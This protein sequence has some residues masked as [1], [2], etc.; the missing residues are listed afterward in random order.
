MISSGN[1]SVEL[2]ATEERDETEDVAD[3]Q[4]YCGAGREREPGGYKPSTKDAEG[5]VPRRGHSVAQPDHPQFD[6]TGLFKTAGDRAS[7]RA[8]CANVLRPM[9]NH[10]RVSPGRQARGNASRQAAAPRATRE[11]G[12]GVA[13]GSAELRH[14]PQAQSRPTNGQRP[15]EQGASA[16]PVGGPAVRPATKTTWRNAEP[17][18][19]RS[20]MKMV[21][22][23]HSPRERP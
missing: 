19:P 4:C 22:A 3:V 15:G 11:S 1:T 2:F 8:T 5:V 20:A 18:T 16:V 10:F 9:R 13:D 21:A 14:G 6:R 7:P 17:G 23:L 12:A